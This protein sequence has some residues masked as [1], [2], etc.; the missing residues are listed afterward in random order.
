LAT[1]W[2]LAFTIQ[3]GAEARAAEPLVLVEEGR[4]RSAILAAPTIAASER[5][6]VEE[7]QAFIRQIS[8]VTLPVC[9]PGK[10]P[11]EGKPAVWI[12]V[13]NKTVAERHK[14]LGLDSLGSEGFVVKTLGDELVL[15]GG[16]KRGTLYSVYTFLE[17]LGCRWW[18]EDAST[19]PDMKTIRV[20]AV[21]RREVPK[22]KYRHLA[23]PEQLRASLWGVRNKLA[24]FTV[25]QAPEQWGGMGVFLHRR[26]LA[27]TCRASK[28][29]RYEERSELWSLREGTRDRYH[30]CTSN[31]EV[32]KTIVEDAVETLRK[33]PQDR[34][35]V[36]GQ[37]DPFDCRCK[38][39]QGLVEREGS[40]EALLLELANQV[41]DRVAQGFPGRLVVAP[42][43]C[44]GMILPRAVRPRDNV[45]ICL[46][47]KENDF[48]HPVATGSQVT[49]AQFRSTM[50]QWS[51]IARRIWVGDYATNFSHYLMPH[52]NLDVLVPNIK[53][54]VDHHATG[55]SVQGNYSGVNVEFSPLRMW[56]L[57]KAMWDPEADGKSLVAEFCCGYYGPAGSE[58]LKYI[59]AI[60][61]PV[62][63][64]PMLYVQ[65][66][67][68]DR[69]PWLA[70]DVLVEAERHLREAKKKVAGKPELEKRVRHAHMPLW[71]VLALRGP[72]SRTWRAIDQ[73][74]SVTAPA[75]IARRL[76]E[77]IEENHVTAL[78]MG[79]SEQRV[80]D[81]VAY[82]RDWSS[83]AGA[84]ADLLPPELKGVAGDG[85]RLINAVQIDY[86]N[87]GWT[88]GPVRDPDASTGWALA[89]KDRGWA[90]CYRFSAADDFVPGKR[91]TL[92][93]RV[94]CSQPKKEGPAFRCGVHAEDG[95]SPTQKTVP[96]KELTPGRYQPIE[97]GTLAFQPGH[98]VWFD[99]NANGKGDYPLS[100]I[101]LDCI[102]L[103]EA[104]P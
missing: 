3:M 23:Y 14:N 97:V 10:L 42:A 102:W 22:L 86:Q 24:N 33:Y 64:N 29:L 36:L 9:E 39:C 18:T 38:T 92:T 35:L 72:S 5:F 6:A 91:Y 17:T 61:K 100:E 83:R 27:A 40:D 25:N 48:G 87:R 44:L 28:T 34:F 26:D 79:D 60:H 32:R 37:D 66:S 74:L 7:L 89:S 16:E 78:A 51:G 56:V 2:L 20:H 88:G 84:E 101:R 11:P 12:V 13:G 63:D 90:M 52:P 30:P 21:D 94:K 68:N 1:A 70:P 49:N 65:T 77:A 104:H 4:A 62:R 67:Y 8:G 59:D 93:V 75:E 81:F 82:L 53:Y 57:A 31:P 71:Y 15:A 80:K 41:A 73:K 55:Y 45:V 76:A 95:Y 50:D 103:R 98:V 96:T 47:P 69:M 58:I 46:Y 54:C 85:D 19:I 43:Y 99:L